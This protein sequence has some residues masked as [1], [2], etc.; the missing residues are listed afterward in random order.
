MNVDITLD[1]YATLIQ[2]LNLELATALANR[3]SAAQSLDL[4]PKADLLFD[5]AFE[6]RNEAISIA[7]KSVDIPFRVCTPGWRTINLAE[8]KLQC[9]ATHLARRLGEQVKHDISFA[10]NGV[11]MLALPSI[12]VEHIDAAASTVGSAFVR[13]LT[14]Q[15]ALA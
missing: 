12:D 4:V 9:H 13:H 11:F 14:G 7:L 5:T 1:Q 8:V 10:D 6:A 2:R 15:S 3:L